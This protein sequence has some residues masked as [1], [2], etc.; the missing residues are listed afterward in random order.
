[1]RSGIERRVNSEKRI[2]ENRR[3]LIDRRIKSILLHYLIL[4]GLVF[5]KN[6]KKPLPIE[7]TNTLIKLNGVQDAMTFVQCGIISRIYIVFTI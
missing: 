6:T 3:K 5:Q 2:S 7:F 4:K 1:M